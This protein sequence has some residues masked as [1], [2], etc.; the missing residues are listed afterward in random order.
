MRYS[1]S[2]SRDGNFAI[3]T[4]NPAGALSPTGAVY[5]TA[6]PR[7]NLWGIE[8]EIHEHVDIRV[9]D[10]TVSIGFQPTTIE[11]SQQSHG[12]LKTADTRAFAGPVFTSSESGPIRPR[13]TRAQSLTGPGVAGSEVRLL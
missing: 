10:N 5:P 9:I 4:Y 12:T 1:N 7:M 6:W 11:F 8:S 2:P 3:T 13:P